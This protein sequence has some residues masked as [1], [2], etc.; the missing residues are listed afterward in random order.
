MTLEVELMRPAALV[1]HHLNGKD[2]SYLVIA[3]VVFTVASEPYFQSE[4][5]IDYIREAPVKL[6][7]CFLHEYKQAEDE[8]I[9]LVS[10]V[11]ACDATVG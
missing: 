4:Y 11:L 1:P 7:D 5:G 8:E 10:Q 2:P 3:G 6:L 9:V